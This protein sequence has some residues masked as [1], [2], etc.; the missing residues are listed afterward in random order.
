MAAQ[1]VLHGKGGALMLTVK[2]ARARKGASKRKSAALAT[3]CKAG[4]N[5]GRKNK[6]IQKKGK[7]YV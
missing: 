1:I 2:S 7:F 5:T 4:W 3:I 6:V